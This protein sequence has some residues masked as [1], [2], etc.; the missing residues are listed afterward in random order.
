MSKAPID[1][2]LDDALRRLPQ[3]RAPAALK[4]SLEDRYAAPAARKS[5]AFLRSAA[6]LLAGAALAAGVL[7]VFQS[8]NASQGLFDEAVSDHL[9]LLYAQNPIEIESGGVHQVKPWFAGRV[10][11]AP[12]L[13]FGG[14]ADFPLQGGAVALFRDRKAAAFEFKRRLHPI[15]LFV[16]RAEG[17]PWPVATQTIGSQRAAIDTQRGFHVLLW[18]EADLGYALVSDLDQRELS[19]LAAKIA[20]P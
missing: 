6:T 20:S 3:R 13:A 18:R 2:A 16:F 5:S 17:L 11:F 1:Q 7:L 9:R 12:A 19:Q 14:D 15:T 10:D 4:R 8:R